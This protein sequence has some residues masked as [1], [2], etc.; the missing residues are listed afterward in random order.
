MDECVNIIVRGLVQGVGFRYFV[1]D[2]AQS[3]GLKGFVRNLPTGE[4]EIEALGLR[5]F[6]DEFIQQVRIGP[7]SA[8]VKDLTI[9]WTIV[10]RHYQGFGIH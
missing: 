6:L 5:T 2:Q 10:S 3:L 8:R 4:V 9:H 1:Y 7:C